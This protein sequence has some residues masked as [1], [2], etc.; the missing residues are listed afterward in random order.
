MSA[1]LLRKWYL[2]SYNNK[3]Q[4]SV[5]ASQAFSR[6]H[7]STVKSSANITM[8]FSSFKT[9]LKK[10]FEKSNRIHQDHGRML[11]PGTSGG[12]GNLESGTGAVNAEQSSGAGA[13]SKTTTS[14]DSE[15]TSVQTSSRDTSEDSSASSIS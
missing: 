3:A 13:L 12:A 5:I 4:L 8:P 1:I 9:Y 14:G 7:V 10:E 2:R 6:D 15:T 11:L